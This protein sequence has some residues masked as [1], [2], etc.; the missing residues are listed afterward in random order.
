MAKK[1]S[2]HSLR[3]RLLNSTAVGEATTTHKNVK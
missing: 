3:E 2:R 1:S